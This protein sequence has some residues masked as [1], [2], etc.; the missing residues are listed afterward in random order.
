MVA[1]T[2][3]QTRNLDERTVDP[4]DLPKR[5]TDGR[6]WPGAPRYGGQTRNFRYGGDQIWGQ[7]R[8][9]GDRTIY[10][11]ELPKRRPGGRGR[12]WRP[13]VGTDRKFQIWGQARCPMCRS[14][15]FN[16]KRSTLNFQRGDR[17]GA[18]S[19]GYGDRHDVWAPGFLTR[20]SPSA[21]QPVETDW[22]S[23]PPPEKGDRH[24][25]S[26]CAGDRTLDPPDLPKR[27]PGGRGWPGAPRYGDR[28]EIS[29]MGDRHDVRYTDQERS[30]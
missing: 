28:H 22:G 7:T 11:P 19:P 29:D 1:R 20:T 21:C 26:P 5:R 17:K 18:W 2:W 8:N 16:V 3:G 25:V 9:S 13:D 4:P 30:T 27:R 24:G 12:P 15:T 6:G 23:P 14:G 10:P